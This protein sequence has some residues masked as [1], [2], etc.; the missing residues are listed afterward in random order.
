MTG[1]GASGLRMT[2]RGTASA[3][4]AGDWPLKAA[5]L[6][7]WV[8]DVPPEGAGDGPAARCVAGAAGAPPP[9]LGGR[10]SCM[11]EPHLWQM[12]AV[13]EL[14][15]PQTGHGFDPIFRISSSSRNQ[16]WNVRKVGCL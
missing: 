11:R 3:P 12:V 2:R 7:G 14:R 1:C 6:D 5:K 15:M 16:S 10:S 8:A 4:G 9:P 13:T